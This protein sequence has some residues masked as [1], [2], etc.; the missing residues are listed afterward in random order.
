MNK[1]PGKSFCEQFNIHIASPT[2][3]IFS[4]IMKMVEPVR[5]RVGG[6][7]SDQAVYEAYLGKHN[8]AIIVAQ[9]V[10]SGR[11]VGL[12]ILQRWGSKGKWKGHCKSLVTVSTYKG[13]ATMLQAVLPSNTIGYVSERNLAQTSVMNKAGYVVLGRTKKDK[14]LKRRMVIWEGPQPNRYLKNVQKRLTE[15]LLSMGKNSGQTTQT[16]GVLKDESRPKSASRC[17]LSTL[18]SSKKSRKTR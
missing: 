3:N 4:S 14:K 12:I 9:D 10:I 8:R 18:Q 13:V 6:W 11:V 15:K 2:L 7:W 16:W 1:Q 17:S 5:P